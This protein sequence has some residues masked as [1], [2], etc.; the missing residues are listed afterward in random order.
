M[1]KRP[2]KKDRLTTGSFKLRGRLLR[3]KE[4]KKETEKGLGQPKEH[5]SE[6]LLYYTVKQR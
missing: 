2:P 6:K 3:A 1:T 5:I 4:R